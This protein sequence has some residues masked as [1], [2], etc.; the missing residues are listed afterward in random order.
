[1]ERSKFGDIDGVSSPLGIVFA[2]VAVVVDRVAVNG[3]SGP[4]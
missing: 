2:A 1:M 3:S 4:T